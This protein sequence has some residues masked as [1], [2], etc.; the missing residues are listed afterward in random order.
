ME[1]GPIPVYITEVLEHPV[2]GKY[3]TCLVSRGGL[4]RTGRVSA[5][6]NSAP[7]AGVQHVCVRPLKLRSSVYRWLSP[8]AA[9]AVGQQFKDILI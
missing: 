4:Q 3:R 8:N 7:A 1:S 9:K 5:S 6:R 2:D